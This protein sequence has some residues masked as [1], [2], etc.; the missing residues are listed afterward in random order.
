ME[1]MQIEHI[2][3]MFTDMKMKINSSLD[4]NSVAK[5]LYKIYG[6]WHNSQPIIKNSARWLNLTSVLTST[7]CDKQG[8]IERQ[9]IHT[10][11]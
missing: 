1:N 3:H 5:P 7:V 11:G 2:H 8:G 9:G 10:S 6:Y 4:N